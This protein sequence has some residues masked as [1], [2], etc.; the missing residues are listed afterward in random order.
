MSITPSDYILP[1][2]LSSLAPR[3]SSTIAGPAA[4]DIDVVAAASA[5]PHLAG[6]Y[7]RTTPPS[8]AAAALLC[9]AAATAAAAASAATAA[10]AI[11]QQQQ[12]QRHRVFV[13]TAN[14]N[15]PC[16][17]CDSGG[18]APSRSRP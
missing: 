7:V 14:G 15:R 11:G 10:A 9:A 17:G 1:P 8:T 16:N 3:V 12:Q 5:L 13:V 4:V 18:S 2:S 6:M